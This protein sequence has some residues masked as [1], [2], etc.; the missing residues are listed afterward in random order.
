MTIETRHPARVGDASMPKRFI[1][2]VHASLVGPS[3]RLSTIDAKFDQ[4]SHARAA[5]GDRMIA[6]GSVASLASATFEVIGRMELEQAPHFG[7]REIAREVEMAS[8]AINAADVFGLRKIAE[9]DI[10]IAGIRAR[11]RCETNRARDCADDDEDTDFPEHAEVIAA[12]RR[13]RQR[14]GE[15]LDCARPNGN[16]GRSRGEVRES[17]LTGLTRNQVSLTAP[18]VRIPPSPPT[19]LHL[20]R[21][22]TRLGKI[23][24]YRVEFP[25]LAA[26]ETG[27]SIHGRRILVTLRTTRCVDSHQLTSAP[28]S[29]SDAGQ[30]MPSSPVPC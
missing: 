18:G 9:V 20:Q 17:G 11:D 21:F 8:V 10:V 4:P 28:A 3:D 19:S 12:S 29:P 6:A 7:F 13:G 14:A 27:G 2:T 16:A 25:S 23:S 5:A 1:V 15:L 30:E 24:A 22:S 26:P